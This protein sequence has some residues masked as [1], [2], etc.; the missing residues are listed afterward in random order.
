MHYFHITVKANSTHKPKISLIASTMRGA[1][2]YFLK[3]HVCIE[4]SYRCRDCAHA[5]QCPYTILYN[6]EGNAP[7][8]FRFDAKL[9]SNTYD[10]G[11]YLF[12]EQTSYLR[13]I[14][15]ALRRMLLSQTVTDKRLSFPQSDIYLNGEK[16]A[17]DSK[18]MLMAFD[19]KHLISTQIKYP[20]EIEIRILTP[21]YIKDKNTFKES[22][23]PKDILLS[24]HRRKRSIERGRQDTSDLAYAPSYTVIASELKRFHEKTHSNDQD[25]D[26]PLMGMTGRI[27]LMGLDPESFALLRLG[28]VLALGNKVSKGQGVIKLIY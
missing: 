9:K 25:R 20:K 12:F 22:I 14:L 8:P 21:L 3:A 6:K 19:A 4:P 10:F 1:F 11:I 15:S 2:G 27:V 5:E 7:P 13:P 26:I 23:E 17:F 18:N 28:E 16:L 24:I